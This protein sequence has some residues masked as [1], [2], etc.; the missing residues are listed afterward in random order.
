MKIDMIAMPARGRQLSRTAAHGASADPRTVARCWR[1]GC[2]P[3]GDRGSR[4]HGRD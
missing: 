3:D 2:S 4:E 1:G